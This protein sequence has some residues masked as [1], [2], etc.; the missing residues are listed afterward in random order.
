MKQ[1]L[2]ISLAATVG[3]KAEVAL[4]IYNGNLA[5]VR[6]SLPVELKAGETILR[7]DQAT[8]Q[9]IPDSV[10]LR[11]PSGETSFAL[12]EQGYRNDPVSQGLLLSFFEGKEIPF[13]KVYPD[14]KVEMITGKVV[15]SGYQSGGRNVSSPVIE[16][17][18]GLQFSLP[19]QPIFP[20]LGDNSILRP[21]LSWTL[22][23]EAAKSFEAQ[24][25]YLTRGLSWQAS[26]NLVA[27]EEGELVTLSGWIT[28]TNNSGTSFEDAKVKLVAGDVNTVPD[29]RRGGGRRARAAMAESFSMED[30]VQE[31]AFDDFHL[32]TLPRPIT[33]QD[34]ETKQVEFLRSPKVQATK[35]Y[36][37]DPVPFRFH[38][39]RQT[40]RV[41]DNSSKD[42]SIFWNFK[43][44]EENGL[45]V[46][47]PGGT[48]R[49]YREDSDDGNLE[50]V[51]ENRIDH[52]PKNEDLKIYTGNAF[53][54]VG[55]RKVTSF[56]FNERSKWV[57]ETVEI[58]LKNR[59]EKPQTITARE[60]LWRWSNWE[61]DS[62]SEFEKTD[63]NT[64]EFTKT[65]EPDSVIVTTYEIT[66][67]W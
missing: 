24:L 18:N 53:D 21:T 16:T 56:E 39:G 66:Y 63:A 2:M 20:S 67:S 27:P 40:N 33:L 42:V 52:T 17:S 9:V 65:I 62:E 34:Q 13:Q 43:N 51:G 48:V 14:G 29:A 31:K 11:D 44:S 32:Y 36:L 25:S 59:S 38:G 15:R 57:K 4:T 58:T 1:L 47:M 26:Y 45:G 5:V 35:S 10:V 37:Y 3:M 28:A 50:F 30:A 64:I 61:I 60:H 12:R 55:E 23:S 49:F 41:Q 8:A 46:A 6:D 7:Y 22:G 19:G 54:L